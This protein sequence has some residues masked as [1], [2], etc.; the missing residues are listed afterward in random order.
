MRWYT[1]SAASVSGVSGQCL[2]DFM[3][4]NVIYRA[5]LGVR[6]HLILAVSLQ[7]QEEGGCKF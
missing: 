2:L 4:K 7:E 5:E 1:I 3:L 6:V